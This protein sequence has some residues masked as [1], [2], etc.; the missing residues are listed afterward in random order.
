M[1]WGGDVF[2]VCS[3]VILL[4]FLLMI[5]SFDLDTFVLLIF[6]WNLFYKTFIISP[7]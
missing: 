5:L 2:I 4:V 7:S 6:M 3:V 1:F